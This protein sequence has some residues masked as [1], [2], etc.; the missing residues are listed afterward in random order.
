MP[1]GP[2]IYTRQASREPAR[3]PDDH[4][5]GTQ[6]RW[7]GKVDRFVLEGASLGRTNIS[8]GRREGIIFAL[9][10]PRH[11]DTSRVRPIYANGSNI[12]FAEVDSL[13]VRAVLPSK[14]GKAFLEST[15]QLQNRPLYRTAHD[16]AIALLED[17]LNGIVA[18][19]SPDPPVLT[20]GL[21]IGL[22]EVFV[23]GV[24]VGIPSSIDITLVARERAS[25]PDGALS[26]AANLTR[27]AAA[28]STAWLLLRTAQHAADNEADQRYSTVLAATALEVGFK[29]VLAARDAAQTGKPP[30]TSGVWRMGPAK[31]LGNQGLKNTASE[32]LLK[33]TYLAAN[34]AG[35]KRLWRLKN[36]RDLILHLDD[37]PTL[38]WHGL[39]ECMGE[40]R[41]ALKWVE[42]RNRALDR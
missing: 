13:L 28:M 20:S 14:A 39:A 36:E 4:G 7:E 9:D 38:S 30:E 26:R 27:E 34:P 33:T 22:V 6:I 16:H 10:L 2:T 17:F 25:I 1:R 32:R 23:D 41:T 18:Y 21:P 5:A 15:E 11:D 12:R 35:W 24:Q 8:L 42:R 3:L 40:V 19:G 29:R 31:L 37:G